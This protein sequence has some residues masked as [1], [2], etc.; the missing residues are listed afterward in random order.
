MQFC[1]FCFHFK[2]KRKRPGISA[3]PWWEWQAQGPSTSPD[4]AQDD[5]SE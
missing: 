3:G 4:C 2:G 5:R 1:R